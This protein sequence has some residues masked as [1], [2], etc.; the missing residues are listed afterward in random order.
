MEGEARAAMPIEATIDVQYARDERLDMWLPSVMIED[1]I[2]FT[3]PTSI[4]IQARAE[5]SDYRRFET[6]VRIK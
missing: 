1:Y 5:Y 2:A 3:R 4:R 6:S